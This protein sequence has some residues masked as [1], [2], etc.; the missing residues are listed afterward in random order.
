M[1]NEKGI[2]MTIKMNVS[3]T[4]YSQ[5]K[6][7]LAIASVRKLISNDYLNFYFYSHKIASFGI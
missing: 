5:D 4:L 3:F 2:K 7:T 1:Y 6:K